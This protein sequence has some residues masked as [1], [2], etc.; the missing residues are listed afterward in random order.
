[1][2][3]RSSD[4]E[5]YLKVWAKTVHSETNNERLRELINDSMTHVRLHSYS[6][7]GGDHVPR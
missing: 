3:L 2:E 5:N 1:M 6:P 7:G 4:L